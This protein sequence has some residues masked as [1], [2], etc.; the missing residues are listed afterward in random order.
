MRHTW[1]E[2]YPDKDIMRKEIQCMLDAFL[3]ALLSSIPEQR[4]AGIYFKGSAQKKWDSTIDYVPEISDI[5]IH[6]L[7]S[8]DTAV[9]RYLGT[10]EQALVVQAEAEERYF[11]KVRKPVHVPRPQ[12]VLLNPVIKDVNFVP[13][14]PNTISVLHGEPYPPATKRALQRLSSIDCKRLLDE[15][16]FLS[17]YPLHI[18]DRPSKYL[19]QALRNLVWHISPIGSRVISIRGGSYEEAWGCNRTEI[20]D[21]LRSLGEKELVR[22]YIQFYMNSWDYFLSGYDDTNACRAA[23]VAGIHALQRAIEIAKRSKFQ[24]GQRKG[25]GRNGR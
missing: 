9:D 25:S 6:L 8:D 24:N 18:V 10:T 11:A 15:E 19:W 7:L 21:K 5:D 13:S 12:L 16:Q 1:D 17:E 3:E 4:I 2:R 14:P 23:I 20:V 22:D